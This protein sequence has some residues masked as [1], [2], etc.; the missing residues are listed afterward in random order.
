MIKV[1]L[2]A[3]FA[4][5]SAV[6]GE[7]DLARAPQKFLTPALADGVN[8]AAVFGPD[9]AEV[10]VFDIA[11]RRVFRAERGGDPIRWNGRDESGRLVASGVYVA[12]IRS[13]SGGRQYQTFAVAK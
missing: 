7:P 2:A 10:A 8:D 13:A 9:A 1:F 5:F 6:A 11:G 4:A 12:R 3:L